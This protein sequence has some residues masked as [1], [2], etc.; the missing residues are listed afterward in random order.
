MLITATL[1]RFF[2]YYCL[3]SEPRG[4]LIVNNILMFGSAWCLVM[5]QI[6]FSLIKK[7]KIG[8]SEHSLTPPHPPNHLTLP[9][10]PITSYLC[11]RIT[12]KAPII[13]HLHIYLYLQGLLW[14]GPTLKL[15]LFIVLY[16]T[17]IENN[18]TWII[19]NV[20]NRNKVKITE[21]YWRNC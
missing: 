19:Y 2:C 17:N 9:L 4:R 16:K 12:P 1:Y 18:F 14:T 3:T 7:N 10:R 5:V 20:I 13:F 21:K 11:L 15:A 8:S 6:Q